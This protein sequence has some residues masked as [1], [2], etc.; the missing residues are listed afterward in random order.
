MVTSFDLLLPAHGRLHTWGTST[1]SHLGH[2]EAEI[3]SPKL[4]ESM[5]DISI[6][7]VSLGRALLIC[8]AG[9]LST[10]YA[11]SVTHRLDCI[12]ED[13]NVYT[14]GSGSNGQLG[15]GSTSDS[16][17]PSLLPSF[18]SSPVIG[19]AAGQGV[20]FAWTSRTTHI[21]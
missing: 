13:G 3:A 6:R 2:S 9:A 21:Q 16:P 17:Q 18:T 1:Q 11:S 15:N 12:V 14:C 10:T 8:C 19:V 4:V 5:K 20:T 7:S